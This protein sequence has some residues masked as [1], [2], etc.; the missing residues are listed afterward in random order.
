MEIA[1]HQDDIWFWAMGVLKGYR[2]NVVENNYQK[3]RSFC[4]PYKGSLWEMNETEN[5][6]VFNI[7]RF[8]RE[9]YFKLTLVVGNQYR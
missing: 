6:I 8:A 7:S 1:P 2:I 5:D 9:D 4:A 3:F